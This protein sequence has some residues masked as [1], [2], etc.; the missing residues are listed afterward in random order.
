MTA[1]RVYSHSTCIEH[2]SI[3]INCIRYPRLHR[4]VVDQDLCIAQT[5]RRDPAALEILSVHVRNEEAIDR[6]DLVI[7][8]NLQDLVRCH[9]DVDRNCAITGYWSAEEAC[10]RFNCCDSSTVE[11]RHRLEP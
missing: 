6:R 5:C 10:S 3:A 1:D 4:A 11:R 9:A 2:R 7:N 8:V